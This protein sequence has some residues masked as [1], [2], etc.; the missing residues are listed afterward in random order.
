MK[1]NIPY[2]VSPFLRAYRRESGISFQDSRFIDYDYVFTFINS[3]TLVYKI[4]GTEYELDAGKGILIP[5]FTPHFTTTKAETEMYVV[6][7]DLFSTP[8]RMKLTDVGVNAY[9]GKVGDDILL[10]E[11]EKILQSPEFYN[12]DFHESKNIKSI[13]DTIEA[14]IKSENDH[15]F[16]W[17][18][19]LIRLLDH[20]TGFESNNE[21]IV[22]RELSAWPLAMRAAEYIENNYA[23]ENFSNERLYEEMKTCKSYLTVTFKDSTGLTIHQYLSN[24][25]VSHVVENIVNGMSLDEARTAAGFSSYHTFFRTFTKIIGVTPSQYA[26]EIQKRR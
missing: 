3:G 23:D 20:L 19:E 16:R 1:T 25:R 4:D 5:P 14:I 10:P 22:R 7:F 11:K 8:A 18:A 13:L 9:R 15:F 2:D 26:D 24:V 21:A 6:H 17:K 12:F